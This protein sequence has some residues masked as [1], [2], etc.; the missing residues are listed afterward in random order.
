MTKNDIIYIGKQLGIT[1][2]N[3]GSSDFMFLPN[4]SYITTS[5]NTIEC[6][7]NVLFKFDM[8]NEVLIE[9]KIG[10]IGRA[11]KYPGTNTPC[12][13]VYSFSSIS[14]FGRKK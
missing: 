13:N 8:T 7:E 2:P 3:T 14:T 4:V 9:S 6:T 5:K 1:L 12:L 10:A 11:I